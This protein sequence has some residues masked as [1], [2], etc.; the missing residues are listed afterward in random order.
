M[1]ITISEPARAKLE[2]ALAWILIAIIVICVVIVIVNLTKKAP[3]LPSNPRP[4]RPTTQSSATT[5]PSRSGPYYQNCDEAHKDGRW[6]IPEGDPAYRR[7]LDK[8]H[9]G[10]ACESRKP[11]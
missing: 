2:K 4:D 10:V 8:N 11:G 6:D 9:D 1:R 7:E 5:T 3:R